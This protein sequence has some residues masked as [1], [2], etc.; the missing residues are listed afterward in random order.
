MKKSNFFFLFRIKTVSILSSMILN[1]QQFLIT[2]CL[3][4]IA[5]LPGNNVNCSNYA[6]ECEKWCSEKLSFFF[7]FSLP[8][9]YFG[10]HEQ[11]ILRLYRLRV[12]TGLKNWILCIV[13]RVYS[14]Y[15]PVHLIRCTGKRI[16][17]FFVAFQPDNSN[18]N[19]RMYV[20]LLIHAFHRKIG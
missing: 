1:I 8:Y 18:N 17:H 6:V 11:R 20:L 13:N 15:F 3:V 14:A 4:N 10:T 16:M 12:D 19:D 7:P 9:F 5:L 2:I